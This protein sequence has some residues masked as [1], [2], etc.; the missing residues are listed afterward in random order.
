MPLDARQV[1]LRGPAAVAVHD[2]RY[3]L[4]KPIE[5]DLPRQS[6]LNGAGRY[7]RKNVVKRHRVELKSNADDTGSSAQPSRNAGNQLCIIKRLA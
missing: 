7:H 2:D 3:V 6:V 4:G 1:A 5:V